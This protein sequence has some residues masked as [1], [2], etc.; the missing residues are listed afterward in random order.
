[1]ALAGK[2]VVKRVLA[3]YSEVEA[4]LNVSLLESPRMVGNVL[5]LNTLI[6]ESGSKQQYFVASGPGNGTWAGI[7]EIR[8]IGSVLIV[9]L[10]A[11]AARNLASPL[12]LELTFELSES[13]FL[14][15]RDD[16]ARFCK[17]AGLEMSIE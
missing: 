2:W 6:E 1:M 8:L 3:N 10:T 5:D 4:A 11:E 15:A 14:Q 17:Y 12:L 16:I 13:E 7:V 9:E